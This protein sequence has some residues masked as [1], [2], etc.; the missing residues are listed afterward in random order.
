VSRHQLLFA[1]F[2][3]STV[4]PYK[5]IL[6]RIRFADLESSFLNR[7][8]LVFSLNLVLN[9]R[10]VCPIKILLQVLYVNL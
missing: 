4:V 7:I 9:V 2:A 1:V 10:P 6:L 3:T 8:A 5:Y